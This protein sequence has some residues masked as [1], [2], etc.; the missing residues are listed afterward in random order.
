MFL[1]VCLPTIRSTEHLGAPRCS[2][3]W[4]ATSETSWMRWV[5]IC[6][7]PRSAVAVNSGGTPR[8]QTKHKEENET[9]K[10]RRRVSNFPCCLSP[11]AGG[12]RDEPP[13]E[14]RGRRRAAEPLQKPGEGVRAGPR[15]R[16]RLLRQT[17]TP[18]RQGP[19]AQGLR[20]AQGRPGAP[21]RAHKG[22]L[23]TLRRPAAPPVARKQSQLNDSL[24]RLSWVSRIEGP[25]R[26][27][28]SARPNRGPERRRK[29][30]RTA[31]PKGHRHLKDHSAAGRNR[32][33]GRTPSEASGRVEVR[34]APEVFLQQIF[35]P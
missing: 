10:T 19:P 29:T 14:P 32:L 13:R 11:P 3:R 27:G 9:F 31:P 24:L 25:P 6:S 4:P 12:G 16:Q 15:P 33:Q 30:C 18:P 28:R 5:W 17:G 22:T 2:Q 23:V 7:A 26:R 20:R 1:L 21:R 8:L 35:A 34:C